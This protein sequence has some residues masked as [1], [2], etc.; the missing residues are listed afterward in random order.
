MTSKLRRLARLR[1]G[2]WLSLLKA[3]WYLGVAW[4]ELHVMRR[5]LQPWLSS[6]AA[7]HTPVLGAAV[8]EGLPWR[9]A[10]DIATASRYP[11]QWAN[12]LQRAL[13]LCLWLRAHDLPSAIDVGVRKDGPRLEAHAWVRLH[14]A[15]LGD[16]PGS[17][18]PFIRL[19]E[20]RELISGPR[21][22]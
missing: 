7:T 17:E 10:A 20:P 22:P 9:A 12:C 6:P 21:G 11:C 18:N 16:G 14:G 15:I 19:Q 2:R 13:A 1:R 8:G 5:T 3:Y 4:W